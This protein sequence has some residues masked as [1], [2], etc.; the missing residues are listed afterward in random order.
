MAEK[1][2]TNSG[3]NGGNIPRGPKKQA[4]GG[5]KL[6]PK[7]NPM[8]IYGFLLIAFIAIQYYTS[9]GSPVETSWQ[10]V[11]NTMLKNGDIEKIVVVNKSQSDIYLKES[12]YE[13]YKSKFTQNFGAPA[14]TGPH[15]F[16]TIGSV[17]VFEKN[18]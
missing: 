3:N 6:S 7:F 13:K 15:F 12:S 10:E 4:G 18:L 8:Y 17:D 14:K 2:T 16:F 11:K 9:T 1:D 5:A